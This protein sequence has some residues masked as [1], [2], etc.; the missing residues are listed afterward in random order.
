[1]LER[2]GALLQIIPKC[3]IELLQK[4]LLFC[5]TH[6]AKPRLSKIIT[7]IALLAL[8]F[9]ESRLRR[10]THCCALIKELYSRLGILIDANLKLEQ[11]QGQSA[12]LLYGACKPAA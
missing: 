9:H 1:M 10:S 11:M 2:T 3:P 6:V 7:R 5:N 4:V 12:N 8:H